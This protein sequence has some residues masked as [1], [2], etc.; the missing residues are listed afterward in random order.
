M[1]LN[2][3]LP[4]QI[5]SHPHWTLGQK[6]LSKSTGI[7]VNPFWAIDRFEVDPLRFFLMLE[8]G[9]ID[10]S[11]YDNALVARTYKWRL[12][13][14]I[15]N[16]LRRVVAS[17]K[18]WKV[19][20]VVKVAEQRKDFDWAGADIGRWYKTIDGL[21]DR[22]DVQMK[23]LDIRA[24][25]Q[26]AVAGANAGD[27]LLQ[28]NAP[29]LMFKSE[30]AAIRERGIMVVFLTAELLR[31]VGIL[32][33]PVMPGKM[34]RLLDQLGVDPERRRFQDAVI[35]VDYTYGTPM[36]DLQLSKGADSG[37]FPPITID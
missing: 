13:N 25:V 23:A 33:Q 19:S 37:L 6:K 15:G 18:M 24:A 32:L 11:A 16:L 26:Q 20:E 14:G 9:F 2:L 5:L 17:K 36:E 3:P 7:I 35:G 34:T 27:Q 22:M 21:R 10:D 31:I 4:K 30:D 28:H 12:Q 1:A 29:W 8:G